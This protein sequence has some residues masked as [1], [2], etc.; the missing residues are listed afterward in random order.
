[1]S[2][3]LKTVGYILGLVVL[4]VGGS[5]TV[6]LH[7]QPGRVEAGGA[8]QNVRAI[9]RQGRLVAFSEIPELADSG[10]RARRVLD[11]HS[12]LFPGGY[13]VVE[14]ED[15]SG[16]A[17]ANLAMTAGG[18]FMMLEDARGNV[19]RRPLALEDAR[20]RVGA[21]RHRAP[22]ATKY[23]YFHNVAERGVSLCRPLVAATTEK[24]D[25]YFNSEG[26]AFIEEG[27]ALADEFASSEL[28]EPRMAPRSAR[29][30]T[31]AARPRLR[32]IGRW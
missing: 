7:S 23:V 22:Q 29:A 26:D 28:M 9:L 11:V 3:Q 6:H 24:G 25:V 14:L 17:V 20:S 8:I 12:A 16:R 32:R 2:P 19:G 18:D 5:P 31:P 13:L 30:S 10:L 1:M 15:A 27:S 21:R 4:V